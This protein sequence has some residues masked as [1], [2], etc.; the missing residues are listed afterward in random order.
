MKALNNFTKGSINVERHK[1]E[2]KERMTTLLIG[3]NEKLAIKQME[4]ELENQKHE[5]KFRAQTQA[6]QMATTKLL[7]NILPKFYI[8]ISDSNICK[9]AILYKEVIYY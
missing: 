4:F 9:C 8:F 7:E 5:L 2:S 3:S 6:I 1:L